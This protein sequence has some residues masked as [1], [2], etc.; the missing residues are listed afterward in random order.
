MTDSNNN[1]LLNRKQPTSS[2]VVV[3]AVLMVFLCLVAT[4]TT[5]KQIASNSPRLLGSDWVDHHAEEPSHQIPSPVMPLMAI[6]KHSSRSPDWPTVR[7]RFIASDNN[8]Q[9]AVCGTQS[10]LNVHHIVPFS[11]DPKLEL[12]STN[13]ITLCREHHLSVGH[14]PD[15]PEGPQKPSWR[16]AN[17]NVR[18]DAERLRKRLNPQEVGN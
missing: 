8:N 3:F 9:C 18:Q 15:G 16:S 13:L 11:S 7:A 17:R 6:K 4:V 10:D 12:D 2:H 14:D 1:D 5:S